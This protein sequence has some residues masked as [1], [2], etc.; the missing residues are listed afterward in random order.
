MTMAKSNIRTLVKMV[1]TESKHVYW[2]QKNKRSN[3]QRLELHK[4]DLTVNRHVLY[5]E[6]R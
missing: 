4:F 1:S 3:S 6:A 2:T 5:R